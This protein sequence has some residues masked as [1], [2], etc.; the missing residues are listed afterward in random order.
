MSIR[1]LRSTEVRAVAA[2]LDRRPARDPAIER[3]VAAIVERVRRQGD[4]ALF[5]YARRF[6]K[7]TAA[8]DVSAD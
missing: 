1:I 5:E 8:P 7:L 3:R 6:D 4:R 2:L